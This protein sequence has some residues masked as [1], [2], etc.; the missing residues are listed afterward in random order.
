MLNA[1]TDCVGIDGATEVASTGTG[2]TGVFDCGTEVEIVLGA[3]AGAE[4]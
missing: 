3:A 2:I 1:A 4:V